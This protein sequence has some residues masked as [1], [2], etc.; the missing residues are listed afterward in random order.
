M[1]G[2]SN[3][4]TPDKLPPAQISTLHRPNYLIGAHIFSLQFFIV[5][6]SWILFN[7]WYFT[8]LVM[9]H[10][11]P[12]IIFLFCSYEAYV[13]YIFMQLLIQYLGGEYT[14]IAHLEMKVWINFLFYIIK[15]KYLKKGRIKHPWPLTKK[16]RPL[17]LNRAFFRRIKQGS[18]QFVLIKPITAIIALILESQHVYNE[19]QVDMKSGYLYIASINNVS[20]SVHWKFLSYFFIKNL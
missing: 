7:F 16:L 9:K 1:R 15:K 8:R 5:I 12:L 17:V 20:V 14:L 13:L 3:H 19:G 11:Y 4:P 10:F 6:P 2:L 18:L